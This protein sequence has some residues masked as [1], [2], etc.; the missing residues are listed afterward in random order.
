VRSV[1][2]GSSSVPIS[3][4]KSRLAVRVRRLAE[5]QPDRAI[6]RRGPPLKASY[7]AQGTPTQ[8]ALA[9]ARSCG[10]EVSALEKL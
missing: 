8:A 3:T 7:D 10:I 9:F 1:F 6:E 5:Q 2:G 4:R